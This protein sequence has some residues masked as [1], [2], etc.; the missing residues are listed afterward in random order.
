ME[1]LQHGVLPNGGEGRQRRGAELAG[2]GGLDQGQGL[3]PAEIRQEGG[4]DVGGHA[5]VILLQSALPVKVQGRHIGQ[6]VKAAV[7]GQALEDGVGGIGLNRM[8]AG[9][10]VVHGVSPFCRGCSGVTRI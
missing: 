9:A 7:R 10:L 8:G 6:H 2:I 3:F 1:Q 5:G 4:D